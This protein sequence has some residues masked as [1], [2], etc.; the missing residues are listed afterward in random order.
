MTEYCSECIEG[1]RI[2]QKSDSPISALQLLTL[3]KK[4]PSKPPW[5]PCRRAPP[6]RS[7][8]QVCRRC[9]QG[10]AEGAS[11]CLPGTFV[12][13]RAMTQSYWACPMVPFWDLLQGQDWCQLSHFPGSLLVQRGLMLAPREKDPEWFL[14]PCPGD[15][16]TGLAQDLDLWLC[17]SKLCC[18]P[19]KLA[20][21]LYHPRVLSICIMAKHQHSLLTHFG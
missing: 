15:W 13:L 8:T 14:G 2:F 18:R 17:G 5:T 10:R 6:V 21:K 16:G 4:D 19:L 20:Q 11:L 9:S 3:C 1:S 12:S 7:H